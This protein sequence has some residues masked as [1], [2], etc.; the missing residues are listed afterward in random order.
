M[1]W[2]APGRL[3]NPVHLSLQ[4]RSCGRYGCFSG[5]PGVFGALFNGSSPPLPAD[6]MS[7]EGRAAKGGRVDPVHSDSNHSNGTSRPFVVFEVGVPPEESRNQRWK[8]Q[9]LPAVIIDALVGPVK[10]SV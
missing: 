3:T 7:G 5:Q 6:G 8:F 2:L 10:S 1:R 4:K 9:V